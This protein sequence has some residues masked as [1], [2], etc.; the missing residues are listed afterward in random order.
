MR[1]KILSVIG[2]GS[3]SRAYHGSG[4]AAAGVTGRQDGVI[5]G[6]RLG[7]C[8]E[9]LPSRA[10]GALSARRPRTSCTPCS[11]LIL[12]LSLPWGRPSRR[13]QS[14]SSSSSKQDDGRDENATTSPP[15]SPSS[16]DAGDAEA[17]EASH[18]RTSS[19]V[20]VSSPFVDMSESQRTPHEIAKAASSSVAELLSASEDGVSQQGTQGRPPPRPTLGTFSLVGK[21]GV[22]TGGARGLGLVMANALLESGGRVALVDLNGT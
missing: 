13:S 17:Q 7:R 4:K 22:V 9:S 14:L 18:A 1:Y 8:T 2:C 10:R 21:V 16:S 3:T 6:A 5:A 19:R 15:A 11:N 20:Q 12:P